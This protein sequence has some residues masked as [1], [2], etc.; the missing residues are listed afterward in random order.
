MKTTFTPI[1]EVSPL[2]ENFAKKIGFVFTDYSLLR[3]K[4]NWLI[5]DIN[6]SAEGDWYYKLKY[7]QDDGSMHSDRS[8]EQILRFDGV[9][10]AYYANGKRYFT[11]FTLNCGIKW[12][13]G[14]Q[15]LYRLSHCV[16]HKYGAAVYFSPRGFAM[17]S[18]TLVNWNNKEFWDNFDKKNENS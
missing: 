9:Q 17:K 3:T 18:K 13:K 6:W 7:A 16:P 14:R 5:L 1:V 11:N 2:C 15:D 12:D 4:E 10:H 8:E